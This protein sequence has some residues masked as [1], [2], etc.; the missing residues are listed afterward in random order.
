S[1]VALLWPLI[2]TFSSV[3]HYVLMDDGKGDVPDDSRIIDYDELV[4]GA[5]PREFS[6]DDELRAA[7]MCY[8]SGTTGN[9][10]GVVYSH[11]STYLHSMASMYA[12]ALGVRE[13]DVILPVVPMFHA[14]AWGLAHAAVTAGASLVMPGPGLPI[15]QAWGMTETSPLASV[16]IL[17]SE[18]ADWPEDKRADVRATAGRILAGVDARIVEQGTTEELPWDGE[19]RGELQVRGPWIAATYY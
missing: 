8:T 14:N 17:R 4:G 11:R 6:V 7:S 9:P 19:V 13:A 3:R 16:C 12:D 2:E 15:L 10:K 18:M 5:D 1:L